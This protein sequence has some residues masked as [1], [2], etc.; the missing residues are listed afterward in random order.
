LTYFKNS[1]K[2]LLLQHSVL[3]IYG[4]L[5]LLHQVVLPLVLAHVPL[6]GGHILVQHHRVALHGSVLVEAVEVQL[7][8]LAVLGPDPYLS[9][10]LERG[11]AKVVLADVLGGIK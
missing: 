2:L 10:G 3:Q 1:I 9:V 7:G 11:V 8:V 6:V 5:R 4:Y